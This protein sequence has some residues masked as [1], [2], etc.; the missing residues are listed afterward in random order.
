MNDYLYINQYKIYTLTY[1]ITTT[2]TFHCR[3]DIITGM[4]V[5]K[6]FKDYSNNYLFSFI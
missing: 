5:M 4:G 3:V 1:I 6:E 2:Y